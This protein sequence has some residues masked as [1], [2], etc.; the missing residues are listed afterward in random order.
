MGAHFRLTDDGKHISTGKY[1]HPA[2]QVHEPVWGRWM[3][4]HGGW[5][6][7][8]RWTP[9]GGPDVG[10]GCDVDHWQKEKP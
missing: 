1:P 2:G 5:L 9:T 10:D 8:C 7:Q 4:E 6:R 3:S